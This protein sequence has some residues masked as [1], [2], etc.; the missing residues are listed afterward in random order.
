LQGPQSDCDILFQKLAAFNRE[1]ELTYAGAS[2][3]C[4]QLA[5]HC[6]HVLMKHNFESRDRLN[7]RCLIGGI[8][9]KSIDGPKDAYQNDEC[10]NGRDVDGGNAAENMARSIEDAD[11]H[12]SSLSSGR[13][14]KAKKAVLYWIDELASMHHVA[15]A[16]HGMYAFQFALSYFDHHN[17]GTKPIADLT[18]DEGIECV[19]R[20][21]DAVGKRTCFNYSNNVIK[22][23]R[24]GQKQGSFA[25]NSRL[26]NM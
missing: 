5:Q 18:F 11:S 3:P 4:T 7:V 26:E 10:M 9:E 22:S 6:R 13:E 16:A 25:T 23:V 2:V 21:W 8:D 15:Y 17:R 12:S 1:H 14:K 20:C 19:C 24:T